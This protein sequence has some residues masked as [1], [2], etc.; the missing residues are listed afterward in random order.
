[1]IHTA[2]LRFL[3]LG[4]INLTFGDASASPGNGSHRLTVEITAVGMW[5]D[6]DVVASNVT[7]LLGGQAW[8]DNPERRWEQ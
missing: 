2:S 5:L 6:P 1:M 4:N 3:P 8:I 7:V